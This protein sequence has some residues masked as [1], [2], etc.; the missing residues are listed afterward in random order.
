M[1]D[2]SLKNLDITNL[3]KIVD[4]EALDKLDS[5][6]KSYL[7]KV[8]QLFKN[9]DHDEVLATA[10]ENSSEPLDAYLYLTSL[11]AIG[12]A[13]MPV[14]IAVLGLTTIYGSYNFHSSKKKLNEEKKQNIDF[15][16]LSELRILA[17]NEM[18]KRLREEIDTAELKAI[19]SRGLVPDAKPEP[20]PEPAS[21]LKASVQG[22]RTSIAL[23][24]AYY[25]SVAWILDQIGMAVIASAMMG[26]IGLAIAGG[27]VLLIGLYCAYAHYKATEMTNLITHEKNKITATVQAKKDECH[28][29]YVLQQNPGPRPGSRFF[30]PAQ[31]V[32]LTS[33]DTP[34]PISVPLQQAIGPR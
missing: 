11:V 30:Q 19:R 25:L 4:C 26:P 1:P 14:T 23:F 29:L 28:D 12:V 9:T 7:P 22:A 5:E 13:A 33:H 27:V 6:F 15:F 21:L 31:A 32:A 3:C 10:I 20:K 17:A 2:A 18:I 16:Q 24:G 8:D 34:T